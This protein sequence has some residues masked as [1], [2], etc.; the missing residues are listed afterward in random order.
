MHICITAVHLKLTQHCK[1]TILQLKK[2]PQNRDLTMPKAAGHSTRAFWRRFKF[3]GFICE[4]LVGL[5]PPHFPRV[6]P[7]T[8]WHA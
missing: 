7:T 2:N 5:T 1:L 3:L 6:A 4:A 8:R